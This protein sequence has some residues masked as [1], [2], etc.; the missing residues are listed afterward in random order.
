[1]FRVHDI[2]AEKQIREAQ[3]RIN[4]QKHDFSA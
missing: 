3:L 2:S 4:E 1:M